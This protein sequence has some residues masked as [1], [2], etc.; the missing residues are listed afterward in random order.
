MAMGDLTLVSVLVA[1]VAAVVMA[2]A[3]V[4]SQAVAY[5]VAAPGAPFAAYIAASA[6]R[7]QD[8]LLVVRAAG[9]VIAGVLALVGGVVLIAARMP[10][11]WL[12]AVPLAWSVLALAIVVPAALAGRRASERTP[13]LVRRVPHEY[14]ASSIGQLVVALVVGAAVWAT[15]S[16]AGYGVP[17]MQAISAALAVRVLTYA[18]VLPAGFP[19]ADIGFVVALLAVGL[20]F[21]P[22]V[23]VVIAWRVAV[24]AQALIARRA[25]T[26]PAAQEPLPT[27]SL[28]ESKAGEVL[29][30][31]TFHAISLMPGPLAGIVRGGFFNTLFSLG[32]D[33]WDYDS[34]PYEQRKRLAL[35]DAVPADAGVILEVGCAEGHN[36]R[37]LAQARPSAR[38]IGIDV[39][40]KAVEVARERAASAGVNIEVFHADVRQAPATLAKEGVPPADVLI[41]AETLYYMGSPERVAAELTGLPSALAPGATVLLLHP[42]KDADR[43]HAAALG[44]LHATSESR[45]L[46]DDPE[47]PFVIDVART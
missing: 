9:A 44:S 23:L 7:G 3:L 8:V 47:R 41:I 28:S 11:T 35:V 14:A 38:L 13:S 10:E 29:H 39:S 20:P 32:S 17:L 6:Q 16:G 37:A 30:R 1:I 21:A 5:Q 36:L 40:T 31:T 27:V 42:A 19:L 4:A 45:I 2:I 22:A 24:T 33:P 15:G 34:I 46:V 26:T 12:A 25:A 43:L 18:P